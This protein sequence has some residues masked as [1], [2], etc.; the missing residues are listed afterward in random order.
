MVHVVYYFLMPHIWLQLILEVQKSVVNTILGNTNKKPMLNQ[1]D[2]LCINEEIMGSTIK[3]HYRVLQD[4]IPLHLIIDGLYYII[5]TYHGAIRHILIQKYVLQ[6]R[7][8]NIY[9]KALI[10]Q[11]YRWKAIR[12]K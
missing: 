11:P 5:H 4:I 2:T 12:M 3:Y 10:E 7:L 9:I 1:M 6:Y 8:L